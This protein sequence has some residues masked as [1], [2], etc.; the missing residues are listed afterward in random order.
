MPGGCLADPASVF[1]GHCEGSKRRTRVCPHHRLGLAPFGGG[2]IVPSGGVAVVEPCVG[3]G[4][5]NV[6]IGMLMF[7]ERLMT[8]FP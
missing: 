4:K 8:V 1:F 6:L 7:D 2:W 5:F 3:V